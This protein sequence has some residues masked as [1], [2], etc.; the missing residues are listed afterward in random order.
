MKILIPMSGFGKRFLRAGYIAPKPLI[1]VDGRPIISYVLDL[2]DVSKDRSKACSQ[3]VIFI[4]NRIHLETSEFQMRETLES[5]CPTAKI[6]SIEPH[7]LGPIHAVLQAADL[8]SD[9]EAVLVNYCD[10][11]C[12]WNYEHFLDFLEKTDCDACIPSYRGFHPHMLGSTNYAFI[13]DD[14]G[15]LLDIKE[16]EPFTDNRMQEFASTGTFYFRSGKIL[17]NYLRR[18]VEENLN[19]NGEF[20]LSL[21]FRLMAAD[22]LNCQV[23][24]VQ[25]FMQWGTPED[26]AEYLKWSAAFRQF[27]AKPSIMPEI[28]GTLLMPMAGAGNRFVDE[29]YQLPKPLIQV[30][31]RPMVVQAIKD[32]PPM[33]DKVFI[34]RKDLPGIEQIEDELNGE[35]LDSRQVILE[36]LTEGQA[37]TC[38]A[39]IDGVAPD[40]PLMI[41]TCDSGSLYDSAKF[42][43]LMQDDTTDVIVWVIRGYAG[44]IRNPNAYGW[45]EVEGSTVSRVSCKQ[46]LEN[47]ETDP[48]ILGMFTFKRASDFIL[49]AKRLVASDTRVN[50]E[51][52][53]DSLVNEAIA[54]GLNCKIF[55]V[56]NF[57]C[58]GTPDDLRT[59][60][61]W[62]SCFSKWDSHP[63]TLAADLRIPRSKLGELRES[64]SEFKDNL[65]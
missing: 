59:F 30:S 47:P 48:V 54:L 55:E 64:F 42:I 41:G 9:S 63:Y 29:N 49:A 60:E 40:K 44:A 36:G 5:L 22:G 15:R 37:C 56:E 3:D 27:A 33:K 62:Q 50:G 2:F 53:M 18:V 24:E 58:W 20:Y 43:E 17:K 35:Y 34:L 10:F 32:L 12:Y 4:C 11:T 39:A 19:V 26:L 61:Y 57:L 13:K 51:F 23:Y 21:A 7:T 65:K 45:V 25:H 38:L 1:P 14:G 16:K 8:I 28:D 46:P 6:V 31:G 52:Y